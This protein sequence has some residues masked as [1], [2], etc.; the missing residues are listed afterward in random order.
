MSVSLK[1]PCENHRKILVF[2]AVTCTKFQNSLCYIFVELYCSKFPIL[3]SKHFA[4]DVYAL[5]WRGWVLWGGGVGSLASLGVL[6]SWGVYFKSSVQ[7]KKKIFFSLHFTS[8][9]LKCSAHWQVGSSLWGRV[10]RWWGGGWL[11]RLGAFAVAALGRY[12]SVLFV[13]FSRTSQESMINGL[14]V[15]DQIISLL[16]VD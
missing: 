2:F 12:T 6:P 13:C 14:F 11:L 9:C 4:F 7:Q 3:S 5:R 16:L 8:F 15:T 1:F 10:A